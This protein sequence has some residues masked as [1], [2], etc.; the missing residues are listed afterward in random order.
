MLFFPSFGLSHKGGDDN[1]KTI[2]LGDQDLGLE[3]CQLPQKGNKHI[4]DNAFV[5]TAIMASC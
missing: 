2:A 3:S 1:L 4:Q 5:H